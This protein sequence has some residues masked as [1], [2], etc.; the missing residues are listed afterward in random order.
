MIEKNLHINA[1]RP[2]IDGNQINNG[3]CSIDYVLSINT[4]KEKGISVQFGISF[5]YNKNCMN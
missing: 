2:R 5:K 4:T 1:F 3:R